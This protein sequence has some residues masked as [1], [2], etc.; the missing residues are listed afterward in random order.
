MHKLNPIFNDTQ[1]LMKIFKCS[2]LQLEETENNRN[3]LHQ[4]SKS[5]ENDLSNIK[6][7][8]KK[9][10]ETNELLKIKIE[11]G[12]IIFLNNYLNIIIIYQ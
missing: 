9:L 11:V 6:N 5:I 10:V 7:E 2:F 4:H 3:R 1:K 12:V 8:Y